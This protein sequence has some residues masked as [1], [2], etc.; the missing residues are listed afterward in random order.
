MSSRWSEIVSEVARRKQEVF[1][2][3]KAKICSEARLAVLFGSRA[4]NEDTPLSDYDILLI[5]DSQP[6]ERFVNVWPVQLFIYSYSEVDGELERCNTILLDAFTEGILLCGDE[7]IFR[8]F[9]EKAFRYIEERKLKK[10]NSG[11]LKL[12]D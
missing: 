4:K 10:T 9:R 2:T 8:R 6:T 5:K 12:S 1:E 11:W 7:E 3:I